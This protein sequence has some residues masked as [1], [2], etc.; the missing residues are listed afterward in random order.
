ME[1]KYV[2]VL[3][4][5]I[6]VLLLAMITIVVVKINDKNNKSK[7]AN[8]SDKSN[9]FRNFS[10]K[11]SEMSKK[12]NETKSKEQADIMRQSD[13]DQF[14]GT[15]NSYEINANDEVGKKILTNEKVGKITD[16]LSSI[17]MTKDHLQQ[18]IKEI[19]N[20]NKTVPFQDLPGI[21]EIPN[22]Q[23]S[24]EEI[25][26]SV[27]TNLD[28]TLSSDFHI[29]QLESLDYQLHEVDKSK[30]QNDLLSSNSSDL[31]IKKEG[32]DSTGGNMSNEIQRSSHSAPLDL[33]E[34]AGSHDKSAYGYILSFLRYCSDLIIQ[35]T[36]GFLLTITDI[37]E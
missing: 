20:I 13:K 6:L 9:K 7:L 14:N 5:V 21:V 29:P 35:C 33:K 24:A 12:I 17:Q 30:M 27:R 36:I 25:F 15:E 22:T 3:T 8:S 32:N 28:E 26:E 23:K 34:V 4:I 37:I 10:D 1:N 18:S 19:I 31:D 2:F 16:E 11:L